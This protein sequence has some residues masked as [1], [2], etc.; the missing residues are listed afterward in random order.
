MPA[1]KDPAEQGSRK[2]AAPETPATDPA[3]QDVEGHFMLPDYAA[4]REIARHR[5]RETQKRTERH[6]L[7]E[8]ARRPVKPKKT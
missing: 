7:E 4:S 5:E 3:D 6:G 2:P 1:K 8:D